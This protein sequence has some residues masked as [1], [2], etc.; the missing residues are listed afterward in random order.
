MLYLLDANVMITAHNTYY[1]IDKVPEF[2]GWVQHQG[3][4]GSV[5]IPLEIIEELKEGRDDDLLLEWISQP[6]V[7]AA[8]LLNEDAAIEKVQRVVNEGYADDLSD[9]EVE[10]LGR[11]PFLI[12]YALEI[13]E[14]AVI[15]TEV[16]KPSKQRHNRK[17]PDICN[18]FSID[19][20]DPFYLNRV[21][22]FHTGWSP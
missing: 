13:D 21:L 8:L 11:D 18:G 3:E 14:R 9:D 6:D 15:T 10:S 4:S 17:I 2:W 20:F 7:E 16:S 12:S 22:D 5:K 1:P 19:C